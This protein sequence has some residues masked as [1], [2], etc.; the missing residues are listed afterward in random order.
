MGG[1]DASGSEIR[2][3]L[4][5]DDPSLAAVMRRLLERTPKGAAGAGFRMEWADSLAMGIDR[6]AGRGFDAVL[7]D[8]MLPDSSGLG[9]ISRLRDAYP[10]LPIV[11]LTALDEPALGIEAVREGRRTTWTRRR[12]TPTSWCA[13]CGMPSSTPRA[14]ANWSPSSP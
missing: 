7:L 5:E 9:T 6:L 10:G 1:V 4:I 13:P 8:L 11:V 2:V 3:L 14:S 12:S